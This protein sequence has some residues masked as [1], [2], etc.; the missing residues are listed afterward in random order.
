M[1]DPASIYQVWLD[2]VSAAVLDFDPVVLRAAF[3]L[4]FLVRT[5]HAES[6]CETEADLLNDIETFGN[7]LKTMGATHYIRLVGKA[8]YISE[9]YVEGWHTTHTLRGAV[10]VLPSYKSRTVLQRRDDRWQVTEA[11]HQ[12][13]N[14]SFPIAMPRVDE[15]SFEDKWTDPLPDVRAT[16]ARAEPIYQAYLDMLDATVAKGDFDSWTALFTYPHTAHFDNVDHVNGCPSDCRDFFAALLATLAASGPAR[17]VRT[18]KYAEFVGNNRIV[19]YHDAIGVANDET[20]FGPVQ[21]RMILE[22]DGDTWKCSSVTN[23]VSNDS[24]PGDR[25][26]PPSHLTTLRE[27]KARMR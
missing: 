19:G 11:E 24:Y 9:D 12:L 7:S 5:S 26:L 2:K 10:T 4:P 14:A 22:L 1:Q 23:S 16:H 27:I 20:V 13:S 21:S 25:F 18:T 6:L 3:R 8:R 15:A 17:L